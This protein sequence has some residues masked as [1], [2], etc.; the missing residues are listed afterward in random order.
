MKRFRIRPEITVGL[1]VGAILTL[2]IAGSMDIFLPLGQGGWSEAIRKSVFILF[3]HP[4]EEVLALRIAV[5]FIAIFFVTLIG[6][7]IGALF[8]IMISGF[9]KKMFQILDHHEKE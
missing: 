3:G 7:F 2:A 1:V 4:W 8:A 6:A 9:Y 5:G